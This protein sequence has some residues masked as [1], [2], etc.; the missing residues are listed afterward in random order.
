MTYLSFFNG[1]N[2]NLSRAGREELS[3][4][5]YHKPALFGGTVIYAS[6]NYIPA[7]IHVGKITPPDG[8]CR[9]QCKLRKGMSISTE[10][11]QQCSMAYHEGTDWNQSIIHSSCFVYVATLEGLLKATATHPEPHRIHINMIYQGCTVLGLFQKNTN[12]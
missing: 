2:G 1:Y 12:E 9:R 7:T 8:A 3:V 10:G 4:L 11:T 5:T 6:G